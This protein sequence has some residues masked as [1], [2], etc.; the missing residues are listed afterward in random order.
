MSKYVAA[1]AEVH[2]VFEE[3]SPDVEPLAL[4]E[5]FLD[6]SGSVRLFGGPLSLARKLKA[7]VREVTQLAVSVGLAHTKHV[8]KIACTFGKPEGLLIVPEVAERWFLD[9][10]PVRKIW[11]VGPVMDQKL[12]A[13]GI[14]TFRELADF[15]PARLKSRL[16]SAALVLQK[17]ARGDDPRRV[18]R[19]RV[20]KSYGEENTFER[21]IRQYDAVTATLTAHAEAV[22]ARL[23]ADGH[24]GSRVTLK[25][26]LA[27]RRGTKQGRIPGEAGEPIYPVL[28]RQ[29][30]LP[31][32]TD[33]GAVVRSAAVKLWNEAGIEEPVRLLGVSV[34]RLSRRQQRQLSLFESNES[35][36]GLGSALDRIRER[37]GKGAIGRAVPEPHKITPSL[38]KKRGERQE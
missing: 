18:V 30:T 15:E 36:Q 19:D 11:G 34:S 2:G 8:A 32:P 13:L 1:S 5:A 9:A 17:R 24:Q 14:R 29:L 35:D 12:R 23:R 10:L 31:Q 20:A 33:D 3:F 26:K 25:I 38:S 22:A 16:G 27:K 37:F 7:R 21:D 4:D 28:T 6:V